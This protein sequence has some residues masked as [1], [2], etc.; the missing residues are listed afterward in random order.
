MLFRTWRLR[1]LVTS[2]KPSGSTENSHLITFVTQND[3]HQLTTL[4]SS[5]GLAND[6]NLCVNI[7]S[8]QSVVQS[9]SATGIGSQL[10]NVNRQIYAQAARK[11][12]IVGSK[13]IDQ[14]SI[15]VSIKPRECH[16]YLDNLDLGN[17]S[18]MNKS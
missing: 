6:M 7:P 1:G 10:A 16:I 17:T 8:L 12:R 9:S 2:A 18:D 14:S 4:P 3:Y 11:P 13:S 15:K 5:S